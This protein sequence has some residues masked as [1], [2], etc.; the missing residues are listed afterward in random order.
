MTDSYYTLN[1]APNIHDDKTEH[2]KRVWDYFDGH[3]N[4]FYACTPE[5]FDLAVNAVN[6]ECNDGGVITKE[7]LM[8]WIHRHERGE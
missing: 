3:R 8:E 6:R 2:E 7:A 5:N 4:E 1:L